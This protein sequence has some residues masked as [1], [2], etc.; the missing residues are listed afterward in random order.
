M[1]AS[2]PGAASAI[3]GFSLPRIDA[4]AHLNGG[5]LWPFCRRR[6]FVRQ[7]SRVNLAESPLKTELPGVFKGLFFGAS[8]RKACFDIPQLV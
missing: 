7:C 2:P 5:Y 1:C 8:L 4:R 3:L 6:N